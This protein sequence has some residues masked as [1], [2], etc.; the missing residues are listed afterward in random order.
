[1]DKHWLT[2]LTKSLYIGIRIKGEFSWIKFL[3]PLHF[4]L[5]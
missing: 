4:G 1:M 5:D 2:I 3:L